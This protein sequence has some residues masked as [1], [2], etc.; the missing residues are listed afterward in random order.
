MHASNS[1]V[2]LMKRNHFYGK[3]SMCCGVI[4]LCYINMSV[5]PS[6]QTTEAEVKVLVDWQAGSGLEN[7]R[8]SRV[9]NTFVDM[10]IKLILLP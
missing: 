6:F 4:L 5:S 8:D 3:A 9:S 7:H 1:C 2:L 10:L